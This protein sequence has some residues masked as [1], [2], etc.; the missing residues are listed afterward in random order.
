MKY[1]STDYENYPGSQNF[2]PELLETIKDELPQEGNLLDLGSGLGTLKKYLNKNVEYI[3]IDGST[4]AINSWNDGNNVLG[5]IGI[6][7]EK[8]NLGLPF[9]ENSFDFV[10]CKDVIVH[11]DLDMRLLLFK[12]ISRVLKTSGRLMLVSYLEP[13]KGTMSYKKIGSEEV[14]SF[15]IQYATMQQY[16]LYSKIFNPPEGH[17]L[18]YPF[19]IVEQNSVEDQLYESGL[20]KISWNSIFTTKNNWYNEEIEKSVWIYQNLNP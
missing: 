4:T 15:F 9:M 20:R 18:V 5:N 7:N 16:E 3:G 17:A 1:L 19:F 14:R 12:E 8:K 10:F 11:F 2:S 6:R 13:N